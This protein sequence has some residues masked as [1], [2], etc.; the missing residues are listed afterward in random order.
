MAIF[1]N[2]HHFPTYSNQLQ[3]KHLKPHL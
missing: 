2:G 1:Y 3:F